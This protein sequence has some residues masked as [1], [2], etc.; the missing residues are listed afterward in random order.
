MILLVGEVLVI[1]LAPST[2]DPEAVIPTWVVDVVVAFPL[3][4]DDVFAFVVA[5]ADEDDDDAAAATEASNALFTR[6]NHSPILENME[7]GTP[8][9]GLEFTMET[10][11]GKPG[12]VGRE[13]DS[14]PPEPPPG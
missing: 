10:G 2:G 12:D 4:P 8:E 11:N 3:E 7:G 6:L 1:T 9:D 5:P 13:F 14:P